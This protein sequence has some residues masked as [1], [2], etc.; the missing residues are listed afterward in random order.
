MKKAQS[1]LEYIILFLVAVGII[2]LA[3]TP[4]IRKT[5]ENVFQGH[6]NETKNAILSGAIPEPY[7]EAADLCSQ[8]AE[9]QETLDGLELAREQLIDSL[10]ALYAQEAY[11]EAYLKDLQRRLEQCKRWGCYR[12]V[13]W[14]NWWRCRLWRC[15]WV[16]WEFR[17][18]SRNLA[19]VRNTIEDVESHLP[20]VDEKIQETQ[21]QIQDVLQEIADKGI[22]CGGAA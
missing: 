10:P 8:L 3:T 13:W 1:Q 5:R 12:R 14:W 18:V 7:D 17:R 22:D 4:F 16:K 11:L 6:F 9:L 2:F 15:E 20:E 21:Q 19:F